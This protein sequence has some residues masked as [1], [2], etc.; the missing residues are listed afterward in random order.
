MSTDEEMKKLIEFEEEMISYVGVER[1]RSDPFVNSLVALMSQMFGELLRAES[2]LRDNGIE[3]PRMRK[4]VASL[5]LQRMMGEV[6]SN[7]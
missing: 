6:M 3:P 4:K 5:K 7:G 1:Y 2:E